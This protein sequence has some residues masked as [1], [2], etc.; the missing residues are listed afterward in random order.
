MTDV[1]DKASRRLPYFLKTGFTVL[2]V[3]AVF[4]Y[5]NPGSIMTEARKVSLPLYFI[6][7]MGH[8][9]LMIVKAL[10]W[11]IL[12]GSFQIH[13]TYRQALKAYTTAFSFGTFTPGQ[14]GDMAKVMLID[15][16]RGKRKLALISS[17][18]DRLWDL[19]GLCFV[20]LGCMFFLFSTRI[21]VSGIFLYGSVFCILCVGMLAGI[22]PIARK[23]IKHRTEA[24]ISLLFTRWPSALALTILAITVQILRWAVLS[25]AMGLPVITATTI[26]IVG[27]L[28]A[29]IPISIGGLGTREG[30]MAALFSSGGL[31]PVSGVGFSLLMFGSYL[32]GAVAGALL[33]HTYK[34]NIRKLKNPS[35]S[36]D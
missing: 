18:C 9:I 16:A 23:F 27:T 36:D 8:F 29:L 5:F 2:L 13:C 26:A 11:K 10:R 19:A 22:Y 35:D 30:A 33:L 21:S 7:V 6:V 34:I 12:L 20:S 24:D 1:R 15:S 32:I 4:F 17:I 31:D 3:C 25:F 28:V 14:L